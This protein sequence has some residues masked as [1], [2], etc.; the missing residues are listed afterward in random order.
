MMRRT[1]KAKTTP[2]SLWYGADRPK[3]LGPLSDGSVPSYLNG[4]YPGD[5]GWDTAGLSA[6]PET[7]AKCACAPPPTHP[8]SCARLRRRPIMHIRDPHSAGCCAGTA[9]SR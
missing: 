9:R 3:W 6:D 5:Y 8:P 7:F 4:E 1:I 2:T